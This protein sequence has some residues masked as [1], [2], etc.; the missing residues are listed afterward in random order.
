MMEITISRVS[1]EQPVII[2]D[3]ML[4]QQQ[5]SLYQTV[6]HRIQH[7]LRPVSYTHLDVYKR[8]VQERIFQSFQI[9]LSHFTILVIVPENVQV[10]LIMLLNQHMM[11]HVKYKLLITL[12]P[13]RGCRTKKLVRCPFFMLMWYII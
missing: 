13:Q 7:S 11:L 8:Q 3:F 2:T 4:M 9:V 12:L 1:M 5:V 6:Q 10:I